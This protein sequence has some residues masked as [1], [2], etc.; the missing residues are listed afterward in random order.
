MRT[1]K[2]GFTLVEL[3]VVIAIIGILIG[4]LLP[5]VQQVREAA[6]RTACMNNLR[7]LALGVHNFSSV[8]GEDFPM[9]GEAQ[10]GAHWTAFILPFIEQNNAFEALSF[11]SNNWASSS[12]LANADINSSSRVVRQIAACELNVNIFHC[13]SS[14]ANKPIL[15]GS[16]WSTPWFVAKRQPCNYL[17]VVTGLQANDWRPG[18]ASGVKHHSDLDGIFITRS[19]DRSRLSQGGMGGATT[20][21]SIQDGT[22][23][24][25]MIGEGEPD[26][27]LAS[28]AAGSESRNAGRK[29]HWAMGGDDFDNWEGLDWSEQGGSTAVAI[30]YPKPSS[31]P[32]DLSV[33][34]GAYE[35]SFGSSHPGGANFAAADGSTH[36][37]TASIDPI[38]FSNAGTRAG[39]EVDD[40]F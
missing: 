7:Q 35:V 16:T 5:A 30:N 2:Q 17:G 21:G 19:L 3:L 28:I 36:F 12:P 34:W 9:L 27:E 37:V 4:M 26:P 39:G 20:F 1:P 33:E 6:R 11:G 10:E 18:S 13:P 32:S 8:Y 23:N 22:S 40:E 25:L 38:V 29:D 24:T 31:P 14:L 15:D